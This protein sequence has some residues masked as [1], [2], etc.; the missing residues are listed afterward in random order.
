MWV[1]SKLKPMLESTPCGFMAYFFYVNAINYQEAYKI[2]R[3]VELLDMS[4][5]NDFHLVQVGNSIQVVFRYRNHTGQEANGQELVIHLNGRTLPIHHC[6]A[7][8]NSWK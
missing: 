7:T 8:S 4:E 1:N 6:R 3:K 5:R 2:V